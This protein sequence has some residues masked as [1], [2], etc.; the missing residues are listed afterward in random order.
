MTAFVHALAAILLLL[1]SAS[2]VYSLLS[3]MAA[4]RY[5]SV[6]PSGLNSV[7]PVSI[8]KPLAAASPFYDDIGRVYSMGVRVKL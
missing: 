6:R 5:L 7:E 3:I 8:L 4:F 1:L 2:I